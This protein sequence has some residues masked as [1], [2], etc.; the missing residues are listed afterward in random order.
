[1]F[2]EQEPMVKY[3]PKLIKLNLNLI[4]E[5]QKLLHTYKQA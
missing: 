5:K 2:Q 4:W 3:K 1:M